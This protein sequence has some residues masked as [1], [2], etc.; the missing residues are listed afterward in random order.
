MYLLLN[1]E[2]KELINALLCEEFGSTV[3]A[4]LSFSINVQI[5]EKILIT[6]ARKK[7]EKSFSGRLE[8]R[9]ELESLVDQLEQD[10]EISGVNTYEWVIEA[11][12]ESRA[13]KV[14]SKHEKGT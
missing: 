11:L 1:Q 5:M 3:G 12:L 4:Q 8:I 7:T 10:E 9:K 14:D 2:Y 6:I 13:V